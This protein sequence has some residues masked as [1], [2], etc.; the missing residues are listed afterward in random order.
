MAIRPESLRVH[1]LNVGDGDAIV[2][3]FPEV[4]GSR[5]YG[6]VDCYSSSKTID[7]LGKLG[8]TD[9]E[10]V[11]ATHPHYDHIRGMPK[12]LDQYKGTYPRLDVEHELHKAAQWLVDHPKRRKTDRGMLDYIGGWLGRAKPDNDEAVMP[13]KSEA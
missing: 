2:I 3:E 4:N 9:L 10:F 6:V 8:V 5:R 1:V 13:E 11:C 7:Y 12:L